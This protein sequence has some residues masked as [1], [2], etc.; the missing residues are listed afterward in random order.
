MTK[1]PTSDADGSVYLRVTDV[2]WGKRSRV[3]ASLIEV[4]AEGYIPREVD[5]AGD[6]R[7]I[8]VT[9]PGDYGEWN[10]S[11]IPIGPPGSEQFERN[12]GPSPP[13]ISRAEFEAVYARADSLLPPR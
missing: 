1:D 6:G 10:D 8:R 9:R 13:V 3:V 7:P 2:D 4:D 11:P 12:W 5:V